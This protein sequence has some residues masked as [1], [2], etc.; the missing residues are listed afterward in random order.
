MGF[1]KKAANE[2]DS[3]DETEQLEEQYM[4]LYPKIGRDFVHKEDLEAMLRQIMR[5]LDPAGLSPIDISD[6]SEARHRA[7]EYKTFLDDD[8]SG[9]EVYPDLIKLGDE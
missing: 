4:K 1:L 2:E 6:D 8:K 7:S 9:A 3:S 5:L